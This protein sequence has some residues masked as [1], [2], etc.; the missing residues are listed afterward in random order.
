[1]NVRFTGRHVGIPTADRDHVEEKLAGLAK[2]HRGLDDV[3]VRVMLDGGDLE[4]VELEADVSGTKVVA[5]ADAPRF[6]AAFDGAVEALRHQI[7]RRKEKVVG[8]RRRAGRTVPKKEA[9]E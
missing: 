2:F 8:K 3:E 4:R 7:Q 5:H 6:R 9:A 1:M